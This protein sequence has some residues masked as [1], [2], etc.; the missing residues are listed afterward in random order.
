M[1][2]VYGVQPPGFMVTGKERKVLRLIKALYDL[3]QAPRAWYAK[4]DASLASLKFQRSTSKHAVYTR[5]K[6][7]HRLIVGVYVDDLVIMGGDIIELKQFKEEMKSKFQM[8]NLGLLHYYLGLEVKHTTA[9]ITISQGAYTMKILEAAGLANYNPNVTPMESR[10]KLNK[11]IVEPAVDATEYRRIV[12]ALRYLVNTRRD[13]AYAMGYVSQFMEKPTIEHLVVVKRILRYVAGTVNYGCHYRR[14]EGEAALLGYN[15]NDHGADAD[16]CKSTSGVLFFLGGN[17]ITL[18]SQKQ[19]VVALS[20][21]EAEYFAAATASCHGVWLERL[22]VE[23]RGEEVGAITLKIDNQSAIQL[24]KNPILHDRSKH[25]DVKFHY[26]RECIEE[27]RVDVEPINTKA[28]LADILT[29]ALGQ[30]QF[31]QLQSKLGLV[32]IKL[33]C[34]A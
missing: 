3:H 12:G 33:A 17:I 2:E 15:D 18:Q 1:E 14:K 31:M 22:L 8:S 32:D 27:G 24:C 10:L 29:K 11:F 13:L 30:N 4:L 25:I 28:Q 6:Y 7:S 34:K 9:G 23:L 19:K 21:C 16:G 5:G 20:S 26:I